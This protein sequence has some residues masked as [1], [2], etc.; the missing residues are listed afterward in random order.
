MAKL[1]PALRIVAAITNIYRGF[2]EFEQQDGSVSK[3]KGYIAVTLAG[4]YGFFVGEGT[5]D[6]ETIDK[7]GKLGR[8][9]TVEFTQLKPSK[10]KRSSANST[11]SGGG[12]KVE[13]DQF[14]IL[15]A[16][17]LSIDKGEESKIVIVEGLE[18]VKEEERT[19]KAK[20]KAGYSTV[21]KLAEGDLKTGQVVTGDEEY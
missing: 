8:V 2:N 19:F 1:K 17:I 5:P 16:D 9:V 15:D 6:Y 10:K 14:D 11:E 4:D 3:G 7:Y 21:E 18:E 20:R 12:A 13:T